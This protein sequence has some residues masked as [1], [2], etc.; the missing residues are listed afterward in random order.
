MEQAK[1][2]LQQS[3]LRFNRRFQVP[4]QNSEPA[5]QFLQP[6]LRLEQSCAS[7]TAEGWQET[8]PSSSRSGLSN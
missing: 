7:S 3:L 5:F 4:A 1:A 8:T 6:N 2:V